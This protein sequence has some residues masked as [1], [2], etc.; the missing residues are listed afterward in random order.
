[1]RVQ[2]IF[3]EKVAGSY[4]SMVPWATNFFWEICKTLRPSPSYILNVRSLTASISLT[5]YIFQIKPITYDFSV[6][7]YTFYTKPIIF[8][9]GSL[10]CCAEIN[11]ALLMHLNHSKLCALKISVWILYKKSWLMALANESLCLW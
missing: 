10:N 6:T 5:I 2:E 11:W 9:S 1:M 8:A 4:S 7:F 3:F